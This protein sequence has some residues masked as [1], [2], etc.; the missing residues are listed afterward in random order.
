MFSDR[1]SASRCSRYRISLGLALV[2]A[3]AI[4]LSTTSSA[5]GPP[6]KPC[7]GIR[8]DDPVAASAAVAELEIEAPAR[9]YVVWPSALDGTS[10]NAAFETVRQAGGTPWTVV[11]FRSRAPIF[12][13]LDS[14]EDELEALSTFA[15]GAGERAHFQLDW[16]PV[17]GSWSA[18]DFAYLFKRAAV[19]V[20]GARADARVLVGPLPA[21]ADIVRTFYGEDTA[22]YVDGVA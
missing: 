2:P 15:R 19:A 20:T 11:T 16:Q 9:L 4:L 17:A 8:V 18:P 3:L 5:A 21:D 12:D 1:P 14:L 13:H 7:A 22:A 10:T 6:C